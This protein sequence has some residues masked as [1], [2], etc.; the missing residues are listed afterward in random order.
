[1]IEK[2]FISIIEQQLKLDQFKFWRLKQNKYKTLKT[3][4]E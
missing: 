2:L 1:M 4:I 3:I